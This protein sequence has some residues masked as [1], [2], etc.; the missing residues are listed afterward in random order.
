MWCHSLIIMYLEHMLILSMS[1]SSSTYFSNLLF[2]SLP[3]P[4]FFLMERV[5]HILTTMDFLQ[6]VFIDRSF[7]LSFQN[8]VY[9]CFILTLCSSRNM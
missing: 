5:K 3:P 9:F 8:Y 2:G 1:V 6:Y 4:L 7:H